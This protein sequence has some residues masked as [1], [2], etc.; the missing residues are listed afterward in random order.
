MLEM[1]RSQE[2]LCSWYPKCVEVAD[3]TEYI[4][5]SLAQF[6]TMWRRAVDMHKQL[7]EA[8]KKLKKKCWGTPK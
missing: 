6:L 1:A 7:S 3:V 5:E 2:H 8:Q 4:T